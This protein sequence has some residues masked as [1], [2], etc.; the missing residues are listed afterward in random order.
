MRDAPGYRVRIYLFLGESRIVFARFK[1][2]VSVK[3][4]IF[5]AALLWSCIGLMLM[6]RGVNAL[7]GSGKEW[8]LFISLVVGTFK[9]RMIL[10]RVAVKNMAR[11]FEKGEYSCLGGVYSWKTWLLVLAM[12][13][14]G[15]LLRASSLQVWLV[16]LIYV[17]VGWS[18]FWSSRKVWMR[19]RYFAGQHFPEEDGDYREGRH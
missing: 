17:T 1:P 13:A 9:S 11:I 6:W 4:R 2:D 3:T 14:M 5:L 16:G 7:A 19:L 15:R 8:L 10:D 18:L 12:I